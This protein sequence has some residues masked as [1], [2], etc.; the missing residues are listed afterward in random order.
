MNK[1]LL[2][3]GFTLNLSLLFAQDCNKN[4]F[5][6][7]EVMKLSAY[8]KDLE[9]RILEK[10]PGDTALIAQLKGDYSKDLCGYTDSSVIIISNYL[11]EL[12]KKDSINNIPPVVVPVEVVEVT[13]PTPPAPP[14]PA[15]PEYDKTILFGVNSSVIKVAK[16]DALVAQMKADPKM[17]IQLDGYAD[18][19]ASDEF[20]LALSKRRAR[21]VKDYLV[22]KGIAASR[23]T[24][25]AHGEKD[26]AASNDTEEGRALN[27][28]VTISI[29]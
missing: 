26:P 2:V 1:L 9:K 12:E 17:T 15:A 8:G 22:S 25:N 29:K 10:N 7:E 23:I 20:N 18:A 24:T 16:L 28:R 19:T 11:K 5:S 14:A 4:V 3:V 21:A 27:R 6:E 13:P